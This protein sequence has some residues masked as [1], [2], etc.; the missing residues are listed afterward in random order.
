MRLFAKIFRKKQAAPPP[1]LMPP[2]ASPAPPGASRMM[3]VWDNYGRLGEIPREECGAKCYPSISG[4]R[5]TTRRTSL[6]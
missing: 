1:T 6:T 3:K 4:I 5:G 2:L